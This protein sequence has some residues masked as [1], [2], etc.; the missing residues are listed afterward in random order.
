[1]IKFIMIKP[2]GFKNT[3]SILLAGLYGRRLVTT[4]SSND[5]RGDIGASWYFV[6]FVPH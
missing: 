4:K 5:G 6:G 2:H 1:M 3:N